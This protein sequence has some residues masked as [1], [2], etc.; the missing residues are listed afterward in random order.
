MGPLLP[1]KVGDGTTFTS[2]SRGWNHIYL[3]NSSEWTTFTSRIAQNGPLLPPKTGMGPLLP[4]KTG[5][6]TTFTSRKWSVGPHLPPE[7]GQ[8]D[9]ILPPEQG[10]WTTFYLQNR[11]MDHIY[12]QKVVPTPTFVGG[13]TPI[14][15]SGTTAR[16]CTAMSGPR[17]HAGTCYFDCKVRKWF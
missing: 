13:G 4:P 7:S 17:E 14:P 9:H 6:G 2:Q 12:L 11:G 10:G 5:D 16:S 1:P 3:Q 8:L 15:L